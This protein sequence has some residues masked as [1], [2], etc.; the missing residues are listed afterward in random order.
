MKKL[1][2]LLNFVWLPLS[3]S[4]GQ[5]IDRLEYF[6]DNDPGVGNGINLPFSPSLQKELNNYSF[7]I[8]QSL[9]NA[10]GKLFIRARYDNGNWGIVFEKPEL[11]VFVPNT[12][13]VK[14]E[15]FI[16]TDPGFGNG[17]NIPITAGQVNLTNVTFNIPNA[18][19]TVGTDY[20]FVRTKNEAGIWSEIMMKQLDNIPAIQALA[21]VKAEYFIN[22]DPGFGNGVNIPIT[23]GQ[24]NL[25]NVSF[26]IPSASMTAGTDYLFVR[27]KNE[28]G[29]WSEIMMKQLDN[30]PAIQS[31]TI[32]KAE[33]FINTD[34]GFDNGVNI[35]ITAGQINLTNVNFTIPNASMTAGTDYLFVRTKN[36]AGVWSEIMMKQLDNI[37]SSQFSA[38]AK[39]EYFIN[40]DPGFGNGVNIPITAGQ[41]NLTNV[42]FNI[43]SASMTAGTDYLFVRTKNE[44]GV[45]SEIM[46][47]QLDNIPSSQFS[48]IAKAEYFI[49]TDPGYGN[50]GNIPITAGQVN[51]TN[52]TFNIPNASMTVGTDYLFVRTKNEAGI[53]SEIMMKQL[54]N[55]PAIQALAIVKAEYFINTDPG[56]GNGVNIPITAGQINLTNVSF[57]IPSASM[58]AGTDYLFV[59]TK[60]EAGVW[61]E[62]MMKQLDNIPA[63]QSPTIVKA[64]YFINTDPGFDNGVNIPI[65]AGQ[66]NLTNVSFNIPSAS[67][68]AGTDYLFV[69]TKNEAGVWSEIMMKQLDNIPSSQFSAIAKAEYF[70]NTDP[71]FGNGV[72]ISIT[73]GQIDLTNVNFT[74]PSASMTAGTDYLFVRTKN[75]AGVWSEIMMKQLDNNPSSQ[76]SAIAKAEYFI[77]TDP[78]FGNGVNIP[79]TA[80][81]INL[82]NVTFS[83][84]SASMMA[85][86]DYLFVRTKNEAGVWSEIMIKQLDNI[87]ATQSPSI[88]KA[89]YFLNTD[90]G[91]GNGVNIPIAAGQVSLNNVN[92]NVNTNITGLP[93]GI[94]KVFIRSKSEKNV[95]SEPLAYDIFIKTGHLE[96]IPSPDSICI[97]APLTVNFVSNTLITTPETVNIYLSNS[98]GLFDSKILI[99]SGTFTNTQGG[100]I[101]ALIPQNLDIKLG[102]KI[103]AETSSRQGFGSSPVALK[104]CLTTPCNQAI[105]LIS[106]TDDINDN[107][108][109]KSTN[110][111]IKANNKI[112]GSSQVILTAGKSILMDAINGVFEVNSGVIFEAK[113]GGC[114][115]P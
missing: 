43:P 18:S 82:T 84:P 92:F 58:T 56:F 66:I 13:I 69:R 22:T 34:P 59:R 29:V 95:W 24:I 27:T 68:T 3:F 4:Y 65:T 39:A 25:T 57:N 12:V 7:N 10:A 71:G 45:W 60:N 1:L 14:A 73:A 9:F 61:S 31:P 106:P 70:I 100:S 37:P 99:G 67:M 49:N 20:L 38:I 36:E 40:T 21:I 8:P 26:N 28:A 102:Y 97:N 62:I 16:N 108:I 53:W 6:L 115:N 111:T 75:E 89:E 93:D 2:V 104:T 110:L 79:I 96:I 17:V 54:D 76:F 94:H 86:T 87:P 33:Y 63:I 114:I 81:Q 113:I 109:S 107:T 19:M 80:G 112:T 91:F 55:I 47:K 48:A 103:I 64:E 23:A 78:G 46:M 42:S 51:L 83:I 88:V 5:N 30:I 52:V 50:G 74:I 15:Y 101:Q 44:A 77:N 41:I 11:S 90:P 35:P 72:N 32:V 105:T 98:V 85:G